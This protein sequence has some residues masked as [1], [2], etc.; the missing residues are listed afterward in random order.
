[1]P[2]HDSLLRIYQA[3]MQAAGEMSHKYITKKKTN[4]VR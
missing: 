1:M 3:G 4:T 2:S